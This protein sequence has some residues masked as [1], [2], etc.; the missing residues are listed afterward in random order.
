MLF[1][2]KHINTLPNIALL[3]TI[4]LYPLAYSELLVGRDSVLYNLTQNSECLVGA[5][6]LLEKVSN[7]EKWVIQDLV[8]SAVNPGFVWKAPP[9][10]LSQSRQNIPGK[11]PEVSLAAFYSCHPLSD[12]ICGS[13]EPRTEGFMFSFP[14]LTVQHRLKDTY[15]S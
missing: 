1:F 14:F 13:L 9:S 7:D 3:Y 5:C 4:I 10:T 12:R 2:L 15:F 11:P 6:Q 8:L